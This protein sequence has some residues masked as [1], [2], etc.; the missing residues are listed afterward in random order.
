MLKNEK[1]SNSQ[2]KF[3]VATAG[4]QIPGSKLENPDL[5]LIYSM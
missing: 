4:Y 3:K 1:K 2:V 5:N